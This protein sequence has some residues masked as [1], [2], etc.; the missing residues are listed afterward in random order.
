MG[1]DVLYHINH[2]YAQAGV[3]MP[4]CTMYNMVS[5]QMFVKTVRYVKN[6]C[7]HHCTDDYNSLFVLLIRSL[8]GHQ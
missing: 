4:T 6:S 5:F 1:V 8:S 2:N 3:Y 7:V